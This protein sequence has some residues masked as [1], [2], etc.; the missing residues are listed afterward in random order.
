MREVPWRAHSQSG[1]R[2]RG[3]KVRVLKDGRRHDVMRQ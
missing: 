3:G 2:L 1:R